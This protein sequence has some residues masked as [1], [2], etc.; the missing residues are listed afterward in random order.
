MQ[1]LFGVQVAARRVRFVFWE[2]GPLAVGR[3]GSFFAAD[4]RWEL[5]FV[6]RGRRG[7]GVGFVL[8]PA[9]GGCRSSG[10][11]GKARGCRV[12]FFA[13]ARGGRRGGGQWCVGVD[14][15]RGHGHGRS[16]VGD[17]HGGRRRAGARAHGEPSGATVCLP[18]HRNSGARV[19]GNRLGE[20]PASIAFHAVGSI[21]HPPETELAG[22]I[23]SVLDGVSQIGQYNV[24]AI[25]RGSEDGLEPGHVL[26]IYQSGNRIRDIVRGYGT[27]RK[28]VKLPD[29]RAGILMVFRPFSRVSYALVMEAT[30]QIH[31]LDLVKTP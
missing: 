20:R 16:R 15:G 26:E 12:R 31:L 19:V 8:R 17:G 4:E 18:Y 30:G 27:S 1:V 29:E 22:H 6:L 23:I 24:V 21:R 3:S 7:G 13:G 28:S 9:H 2:A 10:V 11:S 14:D 5:G 25:D